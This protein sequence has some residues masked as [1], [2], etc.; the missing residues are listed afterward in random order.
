MSLMDRLYLALASGLGTGFSPLM[1]GT[2][3][4]LLA[5]AIM[6]VWFP[7]GLVGQLALV[8]GIFFLGVFV[9]HRVSRRLGDKDPS[10]VVI[11]EVAGQFLA[12][13]AVP[14]STTNL[15][16]A[17]ILF[18]LF[19]IWKPGPVRRLEPIPNGWGIMLD[20]MAAGLLANLVLQA[21]LWGNL[22]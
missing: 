7:G 13:V 17:F 2:V 6:V 21:L 9:S 1:P 15:L 20:D 4:S 5:I 14:I 10:L 3:G 19:D 18:R 12:M 8:I 16:V 11:D 22:L